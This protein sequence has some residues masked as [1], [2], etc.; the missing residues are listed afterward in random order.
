MAEEPVQ[1]RQS[2]RNYL[3]KELESARQTAIRILFVA[4]FPSLFAVLFFNYGIE[5]LGPS[6]ASV[7]NYLAPVIIA[8]L[9]YVFLG[10]AIAAFHVIGAVL[11]ISGVYIT[12]RN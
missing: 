4:I 2:L 8:L 9:A 1:R 10:E 12:A 5:K 7:Y 6:K 3:E 11:I